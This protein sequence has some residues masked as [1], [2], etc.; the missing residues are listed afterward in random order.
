MISLSQG[1]S[2]DNKICIFN[3]GGHFIG[4]PYK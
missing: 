3:N 2:N 4:V 1:D